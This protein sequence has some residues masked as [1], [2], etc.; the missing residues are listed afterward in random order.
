[1]RSVWLVVGGVLVALIGLLFTLQG[2]GVV[3][4]SPMTGTTLWSIL[5]PIIIVVGLV[6]LALGAR[7]RRG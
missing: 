3:K 2:V 6:I 5:G 4:G 1:M 7:R